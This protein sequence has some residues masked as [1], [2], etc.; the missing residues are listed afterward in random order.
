MKKLLVLL[1]LL[2]ALLHARV[3]VPGLPDPTLTFLLPLSLALRPIGFA[4]LAF[5]AGILRDG[6]MPEVPWLSPLFFSLCALAG[7]AFRTLMNPRL[8]LPRALYFM[9]FIL[10]YL[11]VEMILHRVPLSASV[12][13]TAI[14][15]F[16]FAFLLSLQVRA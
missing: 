6:V 11:S 15:T 13:L 9:A 5:S 7:L 2:A 8:L 16:V 14:L 3:M 12:L 4:P 1:L 10:I